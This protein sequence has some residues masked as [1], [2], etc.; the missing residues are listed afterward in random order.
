[1]RKESW[2]KDED[3]DCCIV[4]SNTSDIAY[5]KIVAKRIPFSTEWK[6]WPEINNHKDENVGINLPNKK[7]AISMISSM[8]KIINN[9]LVE[10]NKSGKTIEE[11]IKNVKLF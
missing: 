8:K 4:W 10:A 11:V 1:M 3:S 9:H 5:V 7:C 6:M 2:K